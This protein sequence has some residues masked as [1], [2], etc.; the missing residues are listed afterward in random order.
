MDLEDI[1]KY[2]IKTP[3]NTNPS[4]MTGIISEAL[5][6]AKQEIINEAVQKLQESGGGGAQSDW[7]ANDQEN[8]S[9][10]KN[11]PFYSEPPEENILIYERH[12]A[13]EELSEYEGAYGNAEAWPYPNPSEYPIEF[14]HSYTVIYD[15]IVYDD[16]V[17]DGNSDRVLGSWDFSTYPYYLSF[18]EDGMWVNF[19]TPGPHDIQIYLKSKAYSLSYEYNLKKEDFQADSSSY[20]AELPREGWFYTFNLR[21]GGKYYRL[22]FNDK[23]FN[24]LLIDGYYCH[25]GDFAQGDF[26]EVWFLSNSHSIYLKEP[27]DLYFKIELILS[28]DPADLE[29]ITKLDSKFLSDDI[30]SG[31]QRANKQLSDKQLILIDSETEEKYSIEIRNGEL[32][33]SLMIE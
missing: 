4:V 1:V 20:R 30:V 23:T 3:A 24:A 22:T 18:C 21:K 15:G 26:Y 16:F 31:A 33:A 12:I 5:K 9:Y 8:S 27:M 29:K 6:G 17:W 14:L 28:D 19:N 13:A 32:V 7:S 2:A 25:F 11:R 10:I